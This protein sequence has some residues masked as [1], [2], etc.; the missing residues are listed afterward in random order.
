MSLLSPRGR[1][2]LARFLK[3]SVVGIIGAVVDFGTFN[4]LNSI[5]G[6]WSV[7]S[8]VFSFTAAIISNFLWNRYWTYPDSRSKSLVQQAIQF[9]FVNVVGLAIRTPIFAFSEN[10]MIRISD[11]LLI[12]LPANL[13]QLITS[14]LNLN[15]TIL[16]RNLAL[17]LAVGVVLF[18]NF[19]INRIW[20]YSDVS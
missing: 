3:F 11:R 7:L 9:A 2:E 10:P 6:I 14:T 17:A 19:F 15:S 8:S 4:I 13:T 16:G 12:V 1:R 18:W 5:L 20:T